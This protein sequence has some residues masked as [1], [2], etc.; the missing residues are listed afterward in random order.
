[1]H[2]SVAVGNADGD[3][4]EST[5][6]AQGDFAEGV[7]P[8]LAHSGV[9]GFQWQIRSR[10]NAGVEHGRRCL[11]AQGTMGPSLVGVVAEDVELEL[12]LGKRVGE[13]SLALEA[14]EFMMS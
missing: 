4:A 7:D 13:R 12:Q 9:C 11:F 14:L 6:V 8:V 10:L 3:V 5:E 1:M 2:L